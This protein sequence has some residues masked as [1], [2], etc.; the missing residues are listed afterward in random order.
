MNGPPGNLFPI[1]L[2]FAKATPGVNFQHV[3]SPPFFD[4]PPGFLPGRLR[5]QRLD[6]RQRGPLLARPAPPNN[7][8]DSNRCC[9]ST[10]RSNSS[11]RSP[12]GPTWSSPPTP[13]SSWARAVVLSRFFHPERQGEEPFFKAW[14]EQ[15]GFTVHELPEDLPFEG[16]GDALL[17]RE[18]RWL[19]AGLR[20]ALRTGFAPAAGQ[21]ARHRGAFPAPDRQTLL[22]SRHLLLPARGRLP[23]LLPGGV[24]RVLQPADRKPRAC[25]QAHRGGGA[26]RG[27][28]RL[29]RGQ[30]RPQAHRQQGQRGNARAAGRRRVR[31]DRNPADGVHEGG[32]R[33]QMPDPAP[34]RSG[35][36]RHPPARRRGKPRN[37]PGRAPARFRVARPGAGSDRGRRGQ[38]SDSGVQPGQAAPEHF[39]R[40]AEGFRAVGGGAGTDHGAAHRP[41]RGADHGAGRERP[42]AGDG[43]PGRGRPGGFLRDDDLPDGGLARTAGGCAWRS[44]AWTA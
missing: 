8:G 44:S 42:A 15:A 5:D 36:R 20:A 29:Q 23:A 11:R 16:A 35:A 25:R 39:Q 7:G 43:D 32:R 41:R 34:G 17:D 21:V 24:R 27:E 37:P 33:G 1:S 2:R 13:A 19:W 6:G 31:A 30:R 38:F 14:F 9:A 28:F 4:V 26:R 12:A 3:K 22:P 40:A 18:G 10:P